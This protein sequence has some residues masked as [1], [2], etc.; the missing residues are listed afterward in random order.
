MIANI[1]IEFYGN[2]S[3]INVLM[4]VC[5]IICKTPIYIWNMVVKMMNMIIRK[6]RNLHFEHAGQG[7]DFVV[8]E[9]ESIS[10]QI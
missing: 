8:G 4:V 2:S 7:D 3:T 5:L 9:K 6:N 10:Y 1:L